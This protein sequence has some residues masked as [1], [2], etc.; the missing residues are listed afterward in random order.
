MKNIP[1]F[2]GRRIAEQVR[3]GKSSPASGLADR[4]GIRAAHLV[5]DGLSAR[6][7]EP[8]L[9]D[10]LELQLPLLAR[11][12]KGFGRA[13]RPRCWND[14]PR[15]L[16]SCR[17][18]PGG[19]RRIQSRHPAGPGVPAR[20]FPR[21]VFLA[22]VGHR[23]LLGRRLRRRPRGDAAA[24][25]PRRNG[26]AVPASDPADRRSAWREGRTG[27]G[28]AYPVTRPLSRLVPLVRR[29]AEAGQGRR[30]ALQDGSAEW[31]SGR[32]QWSWKPAGWC[33]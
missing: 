15:A 30:D 23:L 18:L 22:A 5:M 16:Q 13:R 29:S 27:G 12:F 11:M 26:H 25:E 6:W 14:W 2:A 28:T 17:W 32:L 33:A 8:V 3:T 9:V 4:M 20:P 10:A 31:R 24:H 7:H 1:V 19:E 21:R